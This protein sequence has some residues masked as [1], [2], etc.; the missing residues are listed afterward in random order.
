M[1]PKLSALCIFICAF[2]TQS[3]A[4]SWRQQQIITGTK[5]L[6]KSFDYDG[7]KLIATDY[8]QACIFQWQDTGWVKKYTL[9]MP[10]EDTTL[11]AAIF[12]DC[13]I[14]GAPDQNLAH[15]FQYN[16]SGW[17]DVKILEP[18]N[19]AESDQF[20]YA[21]KMDYNFIFV[22]SIYDDEGAGDCGSVYVYQR[23]GS[24]W[25]PLQKLVPSGAHKTS[26]FG[27]C[28]ALS[29]TSLI[30]GS[31]S[32][33]YFFRWDGIQWIEQTIAT[34]PGLSVA[35][36]GDKAL[37]GS[38]YD[39][40]EGVND[41][42][43]YSFWLNNYQSAWIMA[44]NGRISQIGNQVAV[45]PE[46][47]L[48]GN[49]TQVHKI[50]TAS[51]DWYYTDII[52]LDYSGDIMISYHMIL[53]SDPSYCKE[54]IP[55]EKVQ[56][57]ALYCY[58]L[59]FN[60]YIDFHSIPT[61]IYGDPPFNYQVSPVCTVTSSDESI[62]KIEGSKIKII[63][64]GTCDIVATY[65]EDTIYLTEKKSQKLTVNKSPLFIQ[66]DNK[67]REY[68]SKN[69]EFTLSF[70]SFK[71]GDD[72]NDLEE[73]PVL[74]CSADSS[75]NAG[76]YPIELSGG[77]DK[78]YNFE[79]TNGTLEVTKAPLQIKAD[80]ISKTYGS[81][82]P[83]FTWSIT[84]FKNNEDTSV[85]DQLPII[86]C[87]E[88]VLS[89]VGT[90]SLRPELGSDNNYNFEYITGVLTINKALVSVRVRDTSRNYGEENPDF[91][92]E[93]NGFVNNEDKSVIDL[94]PRAYCTANIQS[95]PGT[96]PIIILKGV[97]PDYEFNYTNGV[98]T[99]NPLVGNA[100]YTEN[101]INVWPNPTSGK[102]FI[103]NAGIKE[104]TIYSSSGI[105]V[106]KK[107]IH[108]DFI[109]ISDLPAG[110]YYILIGKHSFK[111]LR[112]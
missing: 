108:S 13:A 18:D 86:A 20:G 59:K 42:C 76:L 2:L 112:Q 51:G 93:F 77:T 99:V 25:N 89:R 10:V 92:M 36:S 37:V 47:R 1:N 5:N 66:A 38:L 103:R 65:E 31:D 21:V 27:L 41:D 8:N 35:I 71:N 40:G 43:I 60:P 105:P 100:N 22:S 74:I 57:G 96:Y 101:E 4:Q 32:A 15:V 45:S 26:R 16:G 11:S 67:S 83:E 55:G 9:S 95:A 7:K 107:N 69:P 64:A 111:I 70:S 80:D 79:F 29:G 48:V 98:L 109:D 81:E 88:T 73:L 63:G 53:I 54:P 50:Y 24:D 87:N 46:F 56:T 104:V 72:I 91:E 68:F 39:S 85:L 30:I 61:M 12:W 94:L 49:G 75:S 82:N 97:D 90:Y 102:L 110:I 62:A 84:G 14:L 33:T 106:K 3:P 52:D 6:G 19:L 23:N 58:F 17:D 28:M 78:N 44:N 34:V